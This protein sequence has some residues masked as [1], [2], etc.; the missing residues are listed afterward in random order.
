M[1]FYVI[2]HSYISAV[3]RSRPFSSRKSFYRHK[4]LRP[5]AKRISKIERQLKLNC[6]ER[7]AQQSRLS[8]KR[9]QRRVERIEHH[10]KKE[11][12]QA[13]ITLSPKHCLKLLLP[14]AKNWQIIGTFLDIPEQILDQIESDHRGNCQRC[15]REVI[16]SWLKL[17][18]PPPSWKNLAEAV[19]EVNPSLAKKIINCAVNNNA[20]V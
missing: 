5:L 1:Y 16:K 7:T 10:L 4:H 6:E 18:D 14:E 11:K 9:L 8:L 17:D 19:H 12:P 13:K 3:S 2:N 20:R 15:V